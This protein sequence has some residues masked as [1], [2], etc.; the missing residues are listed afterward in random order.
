MGMQRLLP[1][2]FALACAVALAA[3]TERSMAPTTSLAQRVCTSALGLAEAP[4]L[5]FGAEPLR[6]IID[7]SSKCLQ[8]GETRRSFAVFRLPE[9][10]DSYLLS[11]SS[12]MRGRTLLSPRLSLLAADGSLL[13]EVGRDMFQFRGEALNVVIRSRPEE[14]YVMVASDP[15]TVGQQHSQITAE[16]R[17][18]AIMVAPTAFV[19]INTGA[20][21][22]KGLVFS[23]NGALEISVRWPPKPG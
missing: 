6:V 1:R 18:T 17:S 11:V 14:R 23:H 12:M 16:L 7:E 21:S 20:E 5:A 19:P 10:A 15:D 13:R 3:C 2:T 4:A 9:V 22:V 8:S